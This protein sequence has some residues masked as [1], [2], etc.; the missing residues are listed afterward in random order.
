MME[1]IQE[2]IIRPAQL[3]DTFGWLLMRQKLWPE[4]V[5]AI[6]KSEIQKALNDGANHQVFI[7]E[8]LEGNLIGFLEA[9]LDREGLGLHE[10]VLHIKAWFV[11]TAFRKQSIGKNLMKEAEAWATQKGIKVIVSDAKLE[12]ANSQ[13]LHKNLGFLEILR[14]DKCIIYRKSL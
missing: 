13:Q 8:Q 6:H 7:A 14:D 12:N 4:C 9:S 5:T 2:V 10:N 1:P 11:E 3:S